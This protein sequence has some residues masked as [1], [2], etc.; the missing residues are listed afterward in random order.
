MEPVMAAV[1]EYREM[2][3]SREASRSD[4]KAYLTS[5]AEVERW[6]LDRVRI[7]RDGR[8]WVRLRRKIYHLQRTA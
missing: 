3:F 6:E 5:M 2:N 7:Q 4:V 8:R 1:W